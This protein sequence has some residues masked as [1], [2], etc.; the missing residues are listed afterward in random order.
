MTTAA[1][2]R[3]GALSAWLWVGLPWVVALGLY[4][5]L[6]PAM[7]REWAAFP[8]L[9]H[10]FAIPFIAGYLLWSRRHRIAAAPVEPSAWGLPGV[11]L[12]LAMLVVG[13]HGEEPFLARIS[14]PVT[15]LGLTLFL[16]GW[17]V[18]RAA[19]PGI[20][21]LMFM[22]PLPFSTLKLIT[23]RSRMLDADASTWLL[24]WLGVPVHQDGVL[25]HLPNISLE[26]A[27]ECSSIPAV[28]ALL[29]L[30]VAYATLTQRST[31]VR[32]T[33]IAAA[34]PFAIVANII[35]ITTTAALAYHVGLWTLQT[36][37]HAF[38]GTVNFVF[39]FMLLLALD[40]ALSRGTGQRA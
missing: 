25:L 18:L 9:S 1:T 10:G 7:V 3:N 26:V 6:F 35:R 23:Y 13:V 29:S 32:V 27:D 16:G 14:L 33:L 36:A 34:L 37:Y 12:G 39:T 38:N 4:A 15:L 30:G 11:V 19:W 28:A 8:N 21:Y 24:G 20:V 31:L 2:A 40:W 17:R 5:P 22:I